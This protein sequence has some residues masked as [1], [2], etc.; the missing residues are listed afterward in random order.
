MSSISDLKKK[1][2]QMG[3]VD[4]KGT[5][6]NGRILKQD[7]VDAIAKVEKVNVSKSAKPSLSLYEKDKI[8]GIV[9]GHALG[10]ALGA[11]HEFPPYGNYNGTLTRPIIRYSRAYG[12]QISSVGQ[13]TDD[14]EMAMCLFETIMQGYTREKAVVEYMMWVNNKYDDSIPGNAPFTGNNTRNLFII[15]KNSKPSMK[16]YESRYNKNFPSAA[17]KNKAQSNGAL[18]RCYPFVF[19]FNKENVK[20]DVY[21]TNPNKIC[22]EAELLYIEAIEMAIKNVSKNV[23]KNTINEKIT[24]KNLKLAF[25]QAINNEHRDV[26][27]ARGWVVHAFYCAFWALFNFKDYKTAI[28]AIICLGPDKDEHAKIA[29]EGKQKNV[30]IGDTDTNA[31]I[32]GALLG[33]FYGYNEITSDKVTKCNMTFLS[34]CDTNQGDIKRPEK[35]S[36]KSFIRNNLT[37]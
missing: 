10:D 30:Q 18:M 32:A 20:D 16:L 11:P 5:G 25:I 14:T 3:I 7:Y 13:I 15:N 33:A 22:L 6:K 27:K 28:D 2:S 17:E 9:L 8:K 19:D 37:L 35:Y 21:L 24:D 31:A 23:I 26:T 36:I 34:K 12:H 1:V 4:I 29:L